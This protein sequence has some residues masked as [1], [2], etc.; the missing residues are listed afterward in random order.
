LFISIKASFIPYLEGNAHAIPG[1]PEPGVEGS[2]RP[3]CFVGMDLIHQKCGLI[4][5]PHTKTTL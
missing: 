4:V 3:S 2:F 5:D 1:P